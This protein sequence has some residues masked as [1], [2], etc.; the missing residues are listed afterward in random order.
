MYVHPRRQRASEL[1]E[2]RVN[3]SLTLG[4]DSAVRVAVDDGETLLGPDRD[5]PERVRAWPDGG[6]GA[7]TSAWLP[8][9]QHN[10]KQG[11][12]SKHAREVLIEGGEAVRRGTVRTRSKR[13]RGTASR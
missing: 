9:A 11:F 4:V 6:G 3:R 13:A 12:Q 5:T 1:V 10:H 2:A 7:P 8:Q